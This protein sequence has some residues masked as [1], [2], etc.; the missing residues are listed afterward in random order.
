MQPLERALPDKFCLTC[1]VQAARKRLS[2]R[3][4][5]VRPSRMVRLLRNTAIAL[6]IS[7]IAAVPLSELPHTERADAAKKVETSPQPTAS[8]LV[9][10][11]KLRIS[12]RE[13][14]YQLATDTGDVLPFGAAAA[15]SAPTGLPYPVTSIARTASGV[16]AWTVT[17]DGGV[18]TSGDARFFGSLGGQH[19]NRPVVDIASTPTGNGYWLVSDDGGVFAFGDAGFYGGVAGQHLNSPIEAIAVTP[20]GHGYWLAGAD[21]GVF[22]YGDAGFYGSVTTRLMAHVTSIAS[23]P[24]G[25]G[26]WM[27]AADG[28][29]FAFGDAGFYGRVPV[30]DVHGWAIDIAPTT[31]GGGYWIASTDGGVFTFGDAPFLGSPAGATWG[32]VVGIAAGA[33]VPVPPGGKFLPQRLRNVYGHDISWPQCDAPLPSAGYGYAV[34]GVTGGHPFSRNPCLGQQWRWATNGAA[35][36]GVYVNLA[37]AVVGGPAEMRGPAGNCGIRDLPCQTYNSSANNIGDALAYAHAAGV[38]APMWWLD[39]EIMNS[40]SPNQGLNALT[41]KAA[42]ETLAKA[43]IKAGVYSTPAMWRQ[44]TGGAQMDVPVWVAGAPTDASAPGWCDAPEK[45]FTG[46]GVWLVQSLPLVYDVNF[47]CR[48]VADAP[49]SVFRF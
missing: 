36:G 30:G 32:H 12:P 29:V 6:T 39:V 16:G 24:T 43:G 2:G 40:W 7:G 33:G 21:G 47:A 3:S 19:L 4:R 48:P 1:V 42:V 44:I 35:A 9:A 17:A 41:V 49:A 38:D 5:P 37:A 23:T 20:S 13:P 45:N 26:Y 31:T 46:G 8:N 14:G 18:I 25:Q 11:P 22:A 15:A 28:G 34:I 27:S 10:L